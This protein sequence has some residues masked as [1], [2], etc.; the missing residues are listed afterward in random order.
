MAGFDRSYIVAHGAYG[1][2][3]VEKDWAEGKDFKIVS[4][5]YFS[6]RDVQAMKD[7]GITLIDFVNDRGSTVF[8]REI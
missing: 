1:R 5:P 4:G 6:I 2:D 3:T 7:Q 8:Y